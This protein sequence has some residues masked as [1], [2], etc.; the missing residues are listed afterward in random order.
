MQLHGGD[1]ARVLRPEMRTM[2]AGAGPEVNVKQREVEAAIRQNTECL[3]RLLTD[4][5]LLLKVALDNGIITVEELENARK[6]FQE[7]GKAEASQS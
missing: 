1:A 6:S 3:N 7:Q 4:V 2:P 5:G